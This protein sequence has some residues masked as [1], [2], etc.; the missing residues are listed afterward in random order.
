MNGFQSNNIMPLSLMAVGETAELVDVRG[1]PDF[2][3]RMADLGLTSGTLVRIVQSA[4][5]SP[6]I[7][8]FRDDARLALGQGVA[9]KLVAIPRQ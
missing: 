8:A 9:H 7:V 6:M 5:N 4:P 3:K 1:T 2:R